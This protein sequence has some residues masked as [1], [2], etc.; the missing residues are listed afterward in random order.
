VLLVAVWLVYKNRARVT[1]M[2]II[3]LEIR[4]E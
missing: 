4:I 3:A 1:E 2:T